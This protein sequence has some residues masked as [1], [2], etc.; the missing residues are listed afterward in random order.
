MAGERLITVD[1]GKDERGDDVRIVVAAEQVGPALV[2]DDEVVAR[3]GMVTESIER[4]GRDVLDALKRIAP[5]KATVEL[6]F[7]LA[8]ESNGLVALFGKGKG[9]ATIV[10]TLEW[11]SDGAR[12]DQG[13]R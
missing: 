10:V 12:A 7:G 13:T 6:G 3:L 4:V 2:A 5:T 1:L 8:V 11:E 9:E